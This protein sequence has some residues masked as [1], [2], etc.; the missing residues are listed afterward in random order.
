MCGIT[1]F[2]RTKDAV[3]NVFSS[4]ETMKERGK[5]SYGISTDN[6]TFHSKDLNQI[7]LVKEDNNAIGHCLHSIVGF[8]PQPLIRDGK[9]VANCEI[10]NWK[11][12][13]KK[14]NLKVKNDS[15]LILNLIEKIGINKT[16]GELDGVYALAYWKDKKIILARDI[17]GVK[18]IWYSNSEGFA[19]ASEKKALE[20]LGYKNIT[21]LNPRNI[22]EYDNKINLK[23]RDFFKIEPKN[24]DNL[25]ETEENVEKL[26]TNAIKKRIPE[27]KFGI[28]FSGGVDSTVIVQICKRLKK[29]FICYTAALDEKGM[30]EAEDLTYAKKT[31][32]EMN[33]NLKIKKLRLKDVEKYLKIITPLI[34]DNNPVKVSVALTFY[35]ALQEAKKD[36]IKVIF[37]GLGSEEIFAGYERHKKSSNINKECLSGLRK[38]YERDL[39]RDD[40]I[41][42][43][44][45]IELRVPFLDNELI[46]Y[47]LKIPEEYKIKEDKDKFIL[48]TVAEKLGVSKEIAYRKKRAAQYGSKFDSA[49]KKLAKKNGFKLRSEY[50]KKFYNPKNLKLGV[51]F[52][53]GK[54]SSYALWIMKKQNY[55]IS[56][57]ITI[58][59]KNP[60]SFMFHTPNIDMTSLQSE[61]MDIPL[62]QETTEGKEEEEI[63]DLENVLKKAKEKYKIEGIVTGALF[64]DYQRTRIEKAAD[65]LGLKVFSP[66]WHK[67]QETEMR[68]L[69]NEKF[70]VILSSIAA[71]GLDKSWLGKRITEKTVDKLVKIN[72]KI[73][74]N[75]AFEG[76]EA[77]SLVLDAPMFNKK[78]EIIDSEIIEENEN[79]ARLV[80]KKAKL[81]EK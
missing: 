17:I 35:A 50:L 56:C 41:T 67:D 79:V 63:K 7:K 59:S 32:K 13:A 66:L 8:V 74:L 5:D 45:R 68:E 31:A 48:R 43:N 27:K 76:G 38:M 19:F 47:S 26:V 22:L 46:D 81:T 54:D 3:S 64:S 55:D 28:L 24:K 21:E 53:S 33:L 49:I 15:E 1:G 58:K 60:E 73:G 65:K 42:M 72:K 11:E 25:E 30:K 9:L 34:E 40:I 6:L 37:S 16:L 20:R 69:I 36:N 70:E 4:L 23:K 52:S 51:L 78:I 2:F 77:E 75:I 71:D 18:P 29:D 61:A 12:L 14:H 39:Y 10:Y 44:N 62:I 80:I 57:L